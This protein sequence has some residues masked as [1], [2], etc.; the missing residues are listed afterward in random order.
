MLTDEYP[1]ELIIDA[2]T[3][4]SVTVEPMWRSTLPPQGEYNGA[5]SSVEE[6]QPEPHAGPVKFKDLVNWEG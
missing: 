3:A 2:F 5:S 4:L 6:L 1:P